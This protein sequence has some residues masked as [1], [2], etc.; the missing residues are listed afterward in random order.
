MRQQ[1]FTLIELILVIVILGVLSV[2]AAPKFIDLNS[3]AKKATLQGL[4]AAIQSAAEL[5]YMKAITNGVE[6]ESSNN[7]VTINGERVELKYGYPEARPDKGGLGI[8]ELLDLSEE[9]SYCTSSNC[10]SYSSNS[11]RV[12]IGWLGDNPNKD[13]LDKN[14]YVR[15]TEPNGTGNTEPD[16]KYMIEIFDSGC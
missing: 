14:C 10:R 5:T 15:Y 3:D 9:L 7:D 4:A 6:K 12:N 8:I 11:S 2:V 13:S 16:N 1:G